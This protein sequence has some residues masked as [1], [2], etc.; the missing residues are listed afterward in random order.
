MF[1]FELSFPKDN[2][3]GFDYEPWHWSYHGEFAVIA[4]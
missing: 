4:G 3:W 1:G 2:Q